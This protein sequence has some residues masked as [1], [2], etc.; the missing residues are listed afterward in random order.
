MR[1]LVSFIDCVRPLM[2]ESGLVDID[3]CRMLFVVSTIMLTWTKYISPEF[4]CIETSCRNSHPEY[5][6]GSQRWWWW[7]DFMFRI[8]CEKYQSR[9][10]MD[11][12][13]QSFSW[14]HSADLK[15]KQTGH[16]VYVQWVSWSHSW[17]HD[18]YSQHGTMTMPVMVCITFDHT[19]QCQ[20]KYVGTFFKENMWVAILP[21]RGSGRGQD[22]MSDD[23]N[24]LQ[25]IWQRSR[26]LIGITLKTK[27]N[28]TWYLS[29]HICC[30][31]KKDIR[32]MTHH[33]MSTGNLHKEDMMSRMS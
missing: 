1:F 28:K 32:E 6:P 11:W 21:E 19:K 25:V 33:E 4:P 12:Q 9:K 15:R 16:C 10:D 18:I 20:T 27:S 31:I 29:L 14:W 26:G 30:R 7:S 23:R 5:H 8:L 3:L 22:M 2:T 24:N 13:S 17:S